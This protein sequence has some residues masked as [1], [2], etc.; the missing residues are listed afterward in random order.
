MGS[1]AGARPPDACPALVSMQARTSPLNSSSWPTAPLP[2]GPSLCVARVDAHLQAIDEACPPT[3]S[4]TP[5]PPVTLKGVPRLGPH[6]TSHCKSCCTPRG[7]CKPGLSVPRSPRH[8]T[9]WA[10][11]SPRP[12][13]PGYHSEARAVDP[14]SHS[15]GDPLSGRPHVE[16]LA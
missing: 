2:G 1:G 15:L 8:S 7:T 14:D 12:R 3:Y 11:Q 9:W 6:H 5:R 13:S 10:L 16:W 4:Q